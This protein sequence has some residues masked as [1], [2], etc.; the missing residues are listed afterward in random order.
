MIFY[1]EFAVTD[2]GAPILW[3]RVPV[4][5]DDLVADGGFEVAPG[6]SRAGLDYDAWAKLARAN[7]SYVQPG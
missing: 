7:S 2:A 1:P 4:D 5:G 6:E 3:V